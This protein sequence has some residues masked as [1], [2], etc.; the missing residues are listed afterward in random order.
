MI[1][2]EKEAP[3]RLPFEEI[4]LYITIEEY[5]TIFPEVVPLSRRVF[6]DHAQ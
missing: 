6:D 1:I 5:T 3:Q 4:P 2:R